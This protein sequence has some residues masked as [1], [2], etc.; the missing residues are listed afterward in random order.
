MQIMIHIFLCR[1]WEKDRFELSDKIY[2]L[3]GLDY[4]VQL[5]LFP[6]GGDLTYKTKK[7]SD[8]YADDNGLPRYGYCLHPRTTEFV[9]VV[10][11]LRSGGLDAV[12]DVTIGY[13]DVI[14]KTE[15]EFG[16]G[17]MPREVHYHIKSYDGKDLPLDD[18]E[19]AQW[20]KDRWREKEARLRDFYTNREFRES[21]TENGPAAEVRNGIGK[22][23]RVKEA[24][25]Q[26]QYLSFVCSVLVFTTANVLIMYMLLY[27]SW[28]FV[29]LGIV[30]CAMLMYESYF[31]KG[32]DRWLMSFSQEEIKLAK[33]KAENVMPQSKSSILQN[34]VG[35]CDVQQ[36]I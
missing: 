9:C 8:Q 28:G 30:L 21:A 34:G 3:N 29:F 13:P 31:G 19:L 15:L 27:H 25:G 23:R 20:C 5:L 18:D 2:Y 32:L 7:R 16:K 33:A 24:T 11:A 14:S 35:T 36:K 12:Y 4:P 10:N 17:I 22:F 1:K 26:K 6:E